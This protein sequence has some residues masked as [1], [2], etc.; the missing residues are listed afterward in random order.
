MALSF[1][2]KGFCLRSTWFGI[3]LF[4][5]GSG[6]VSRPCCGGEAV[7]PWQG[8]VISFCWSWSILGP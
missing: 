7:L 4:V 3:K 2:L 5:Q 6:S 8:T 1:R